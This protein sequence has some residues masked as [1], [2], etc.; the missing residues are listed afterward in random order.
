MS[1]SRTIYA[2]MVKKCRAASLGKSV[3]RTSPMGGGALGGSQGDSCLPVPSY[4]PPAAPLV[5]IMT[6]GALQ[7]FSI[8]FCKK[9]LNV[10]KLLNFMILPT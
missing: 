9:Q 1:F 4:L 10:L 2:P 7:G 5:R 6:L 3:T 8:F